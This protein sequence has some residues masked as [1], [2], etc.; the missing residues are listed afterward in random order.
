M[1]REP[2]EEAEFRLPLTG[3]DFKAEGAAVVDAFAAEVRAGGFAAWSAV[4]DNHEGFRAAVDEG[5][6]RA[7]WAL[8]RQSLHDPLLVLNVESE[9]PNGAAAI[10]HAARCWLAAHAAAGVDASALD[11]A[12]APGGAWAEGAEERECVLHNGRGPRL[13][14]GT[15]GDVGEEC[16]VAW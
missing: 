7:G 16:A 11:A 12:F 10:A 14:G 13:G 1:L 9:A 2:L 15:C 4:A 5:D 3:A 8:L 6:G